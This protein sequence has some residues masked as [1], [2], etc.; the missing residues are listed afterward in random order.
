MLCVYLPTLDEAMTDRPGRLLPHPPP[1]PPAASADPLSDV[2]K[3]VRLRGAVFFML[4]MSSPWAGAMPD[5]AALAPLEYRVS[6]HDDLDRM[7]LAI[8]D[9]AR[10]G[11]HV[12]V[13]SNGGFGG[14]HG[15]ILSALSR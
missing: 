5:G 12:L 2:L 10:S 6:V 13:M 1:P 8:A 4:D 3:T 14:V 7:A 11:D 9:F 15:R